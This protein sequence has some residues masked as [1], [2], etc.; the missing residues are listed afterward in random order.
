MTVCLSLF[1]AAAVAACS[2]DRDVVAIRSD[3]ADAPSSTPSGSTSS[4][5]SDEQPSAPTTSNPPLTLPSV[6][7][8]TDSPADPVGSV[9][10]GGLVPTADGAGDELFPDLGNPGIDVIDYAV[11]LTFD[12]AADQLTGS[13]TLTVTPTE[14]RTDFTL[15]SVG[16]MVSRVTVDGTDAEFEIDE[17]ELRITPPRPLVA[18]SDVEVHV[19]YTVVPKFIDDF[20]VPAGWFNSAGGSYV[21]NEP[22]GARTW[23]P[24]NDHPSDKAT[25][26]FSITVA[27]GVTAVANGSL[28]STTDGPQGTTWVWREDTPMATY[29]ILLITGQ[30]ELVEGTGPGGLPLLSAVLRDDLTTVQPYLDSIDDQ[31]DF[32]DDFFGPYPFDRYGIAITDSFGGLAMETQ[33]R[34]LFSRDDLNGDVGMLQQLLLSHEVAHQWFGNSV[35]PIEWQDIWLN[36]S[37]ATYGQWM[38]LEHVGLTTVEAEAAR[39]LEARQKST[40]SPTGSPGADELFGFNSYDGG[41]VVVHALRAAVGD[42]AFFEV[43]QQWAAQNAGTSRSTEDF[44]L[45]ASDVTKTD[46]R[47]FFDDWLFAERLPPKFP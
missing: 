44:I 13:V 22:D 27:S 9:P 43:L 1:T 17:P 16:P 11:D 4:V 25:W 42:E 18:G 34:S 35:S 26:T 23:L 45:L 21:L 15:D 20:E 12:D 3:S 8:T 39:S 29:L 30:Y 38:W 10:P 6:P 19:E 2:A 33:G 37:F 7:S 36:E 46:L 47:S 28:V 32:F 40:G 24:S 41:A 14:A 31:I 5:P